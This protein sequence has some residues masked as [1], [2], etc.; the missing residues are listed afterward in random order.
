MGSRNERGR[1]MG[2]NI[3]KFGMNYTCEQER[4][5]ENVKV[6]YTYKKVKIVAY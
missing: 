2:L 6:K 5:P 3:C 1:Q 4:N